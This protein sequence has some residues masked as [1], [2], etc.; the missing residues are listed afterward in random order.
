LSLLAC[1]GATMI[2]GPI[3]LHQAATAAIDGGGILCDCKE[4]P[5]A[6]CPMHKGKHQSSGSE[7]GT[8]HACA[9]YGDRVAVLTFLTGT[10]GILQTA[11]ADIRPATPGVALAAFT[12]SV[13]NTDGSPTSP[14]PRS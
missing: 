3:L 10:S 12:T 8:L 7:S 2:A 6:E 5:G 9:G 4:E 14:P 13:V 1:Q 11:S